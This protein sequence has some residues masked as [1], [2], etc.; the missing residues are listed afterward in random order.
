MPELSTG[1]VLA[2]YRVEALAGRGGMGVVY[3]ATQLALERQVALKV[4]A[5]ELAQDESFRER[6]KRESRAAALIEHAHVIPVHEAG[7]A[8]GERTAAPHRSAQEGGRGPPAARRDSGLQRHDRRRGRGL[9]RGRPG[10]EH[11][12]PSRPVSR[13]GGA[14]RAANYED[15]ASTGAT[16]AVE[17]TSSPSAASTTTR[18]PGWNSPS[19]SFSASLSTSRFWITRLSGRAP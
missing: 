8:D 11:G 3:R 4:I 15:S 6:F 9:D 12:D 13:P 18:S 5:P 7:E 2:G 17:N 1:D 16:G 19:S 10:A 14:R